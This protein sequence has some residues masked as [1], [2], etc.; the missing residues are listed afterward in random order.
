MKYQELCILL[1]CHSLE[2]FPIH[3]EGEEADGLLACWSAMWHPALLACVQQGPTWFRVDDPPEDL[4]DRLILVPSVSQEEL[5][6]GFVQR[7]RKDGAVVIRRQHDRAEI[8]SKAL[9]P[10][11]PTPQ[12][13]A[14]LVP[15][16]LALGYG[17]LQVEL[18]TRQMRY[19][20]NLDEVHFYN[21]AV[22]A[23]VSAIE[24]NDEAARQKLTACFDLLAEERDHYY[25]VEAFSL[26]ITL[27]A[28]TTI[29][30]S[31]RAEIANDIPQNL[32][33]SGSVLDEM[34]DRE[35]ETL[36]AIRRKMESGRLSVIGGE[37]TESRLPLQSCESIL[38]HLELGQQAYERH[39]GKRIDVYGRRRYG[40]T[41]NLPQ[42]LMRA[43]FVGALHATL[44]D[45]KFPEGTQYKVRWEAHD[46][47][48]LD[49]IGRVPLS[50]SSSE[51]FL[52]LAGKLGESMDMDHVATIALAHWPGRASCWLEDVRRIAKYGNV[53]GKFVTLDEYFRETDTPAHLDRYDADQYHS[54]YLK[55]AVIR[56]E[57]DPIS[58]VQAYWRRIT[59][60]Q[61]SEA[62]AA[63]NHVLDQPDPS[64]L[65]AG[66]AID[67]C[68]ESGEGGDELDCQVEQAVDENVSQLAGQ[69][70]DT[71]SAAQTGCLI[72]NPANVVRRVAVDVSELPSLPAK[73]KPVYSAAISAE[74]K[75]AIVDVPGNGYA[76][77]TPSGNSST[78]RKPRKSELL[79]D[80][81][82]LQNEFFQALIN[83]KT[84]S[85]QA[86]RHY[87]E[88]SNRLS[89][90]L[91]MRAP[92]P[93]ASPGDTWQD[94]DSAATYSQMVA[95]EVRVSQSSD[96]MGEIV[97]RGKLQDREGNVLSEFQQTFRVWRGIRVLEL[98]IEL[99][100]QV[101]TRSDPWNSYFAC[102]FAWG[103]ETSE[104]SRPVNQIR[105]PVNAKRFEAPHYIELSSGKQ[106]TAI[107][108]NGL[109]FHRRIGFD[110]LDSLLVVRGESQRRFRLGI[111][112]DLKQPMHDAQELMGRTLVSTHQAQP[113][114]APTGW[115][116]H[117]DAR[118]LLVTSWQPLPDK[119]GLRIRVLE[120]ADRATRAQLT[121]V[122]PIKQAVQTN[123][124]GKPVVECRVE[125]ERA[126]LDIAANEWVQF[127]IEW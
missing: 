48:A 31:L 50:A 45:G 78:S 34:A 98:E 18:L 13:N 103:D 21:Q 87:D 91:A 39:L 71:S 46:G 29:G 62:L 111:G 115:L 15:D 51:V 86:V 22:E 30:E 65:D 27:V 5:P 79:A 94:P 55:Q 123:F 106:R 97:S 66:Q 116:Y 68:S 108:T 85:L 77:L 105:H 113:R 49:A 74:R 4:T 117:I 109:A 52:G 24:G 112:V 127:D 32:M 110:T 23:A 72:L 96:T 67:S 33:I 9:E 40:L 2:D 41:P 6:T 107:L 114:S 53:L 12:L 126:V 60:L 122:K 54:P 83:P 59:D 61:R 58:S 121:T 102:R 93:R 11:D 44:E 63:M 37:Y 3:H 38:R 124:Q 19:S 76:W 17:F 92:G 119:N 82:I 99:D 104:L 95:D 43:G 80:E 28:S 118:N 10:L 89:Q 125:E 120:T 100:P 73:E 64:W 81:G 16:F 56:K 26:D 69:L 7:A 36:A 35:P 1:P 88:R 47:T 8:L 14:D 57:A 101:E 20:S 25:P 75:L 90:Q 42:V 70:L 84:G